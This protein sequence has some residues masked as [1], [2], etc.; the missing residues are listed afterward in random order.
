MSEISQNALKKRAAYDAAVLKEAAEER[1][2]LTATSTMWRRLPSA[3]PASSAS[4][5]S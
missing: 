4:S 3:S 2:T 5:V 1:R